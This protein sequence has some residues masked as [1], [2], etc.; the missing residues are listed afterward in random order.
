[1]KCHTPDCT[2]EREL[3]AISH[4]VIYRQRTVVVHGV[5]ADLCPECGDAVLAEET[6]LVLDRLLR[7]HGGRQAKLLTYR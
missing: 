4:S 3:Q 1:M 7:R 5:P 6:L 2:G